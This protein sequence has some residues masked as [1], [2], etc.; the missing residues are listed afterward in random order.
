MDDRKLKDRIRDEWGK[1]KTLSWKARL[2]YVWDYYKL[3]MVII[4]VIILAINLGFTIYHNLQI[5]TLLYVYMVNCNTYYVD[6]DE[7]VE[8]YTEYLG[9]IGDKEEISM[10]TSVLLDEE[11]YSTSY[12]NQ[13]KF[14]A[15][16]SA[17]MADVVLMDEENFEEYAGWSYFFDLREVLTEE[18]LEQWSDLL[19]YMENED[20]ESA[21]YAIN[22]TDAPKLQEYD[23]YP[24][25]STVYGGVIVNGVNVD[26]TSEFFDW[27]F[28]E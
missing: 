8:D 17:Q 24:D 11:D 3:Q 16:I 13:M 4:V 7:L 9:G 19:V 1:L 26:A 14:T 21:P 20:G 10:D 15:V 18:Q 6:P 22:L 28:S 5:D 2:A 25:T 12:A 23:V 27:L